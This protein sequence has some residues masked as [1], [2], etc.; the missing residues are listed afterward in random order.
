LTLSV[1]PAR[2]FDFRSRSMSMSL[3]AVSVPVFVK[4]LTNLEAV[5]EKAKAHALDHKIEEAAFVNARLY[6]DMLPLAR[7]VQIATDI[8]RGATARL[9]GLE[10]PSYEDKEQTFDDLAARV[11]RTIEYMKALDEKQFEGAATREITR[12]VRGEPHK[13]SGVNYLL[14]FA[15]PNVY[16]HTTTA[17]AILRHNGVPLG[18]ADFLGT[19]D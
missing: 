7:Q 15:T 3:Y 4:T 19:L 18:K 5:L 11:R 9:A 12:P 16:F 10:P 6:P 1:P 14:Q 8:A 2:P 13:F 17:Y